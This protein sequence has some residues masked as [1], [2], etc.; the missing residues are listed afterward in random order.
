[1]EKLSSDIVYSISFYLNLKDLYCWLQCCKKIYKSLKQEK[2][3]TYHVYKY[4]DK[5]FSIDYEKNILVELLK[6]LYPNYQISFCEKTNISK[7]L[8]IKLKKPNKYGEYKV[9]SEKIWKQL[10][11]P[12]LIQ[13]LKELPIITLIGFFNN[14]HLYFI[15]S[16]IT[17]KCKISW[18]YILREYSTINGYLN[19]SNYRM[20]SLDIILMTEELTQKKILPM[21][22]NLSQ[23]Y[24][25]NI[26]PLKYLFETDSIKYIILLQNPIDIS[27]VEKYI[28]SNDLC[29]IKQKIYDKLILLTKAFVLK[30][31]NVNP[32]NKFRTS[33]LNYYKN[34]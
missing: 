13:Y 31:Q 4:L 22:I 25:D 7:S 20:K 2:I 17:F 1:M 24:I 18:V 11:N 21:T 27:S 6:T 16:K 10:E 29:N 33:H 12:T 19:L 26:I 3:W 8:Y 15:N 34:Y 32:Y 30:F 28:E 5:L 14:I 9:I 23:N